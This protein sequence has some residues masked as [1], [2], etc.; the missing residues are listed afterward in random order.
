MSNDNTAPKDV[1]PFPFVPFTQT[2]AAAAPVDL[3][4]NPLPVMS[5]EERKLWGASHQLPQEYVILHVC[6]V[7]EIKKTI[8]D[9]NM[10]LSIAQLQ[11]KARGQRRADMNGAHGAAKN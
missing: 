10:Q 4:K 3:T 8:R 1:P 7:M 2:A 5:I 9:L 11:L 6:E